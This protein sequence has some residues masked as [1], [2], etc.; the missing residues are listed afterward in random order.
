M[1][2]VM[3]LLG[4]V[5]SKI[6]ASELVS[7]PDAALGG[8]HANGDSGPS[9]ISPDGRY[10]LFSSAANNLA[11]TATTNPIPIDIPASLNV[12]L[13]DRSNDVTTLVSV[14]LNGAGG[15]GDSFAAGISSNGQ[16][17]LFESS[18]T[19]LTPAIPTRP[20]TWRGTFISVTWLKGRR[21]W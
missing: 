10:V 13:R 7:L 21:R 11:L 17:A 1:L 18:A 19:D 12:Y 4:L 20:I 6:S 5:L 14:N 8:S 15:N 3:V 2:T 16:F 9:I